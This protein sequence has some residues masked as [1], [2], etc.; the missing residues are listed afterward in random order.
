M[1]LKSDSNSDLI[2]EFLEFSL[3][4]VLVVL[5]LIF[6]LDV[7]L[8]KAPGHH[9]DAGCKRDLV[10]ETVCLSSIYFHLHVGESDKG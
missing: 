2:F 9:G 3:V 8:G 1:R 6:T 5:W 10:N 4:N 7:R